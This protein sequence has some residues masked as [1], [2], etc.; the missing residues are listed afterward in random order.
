MQKVFGIAG[1][2][3]SGKTTLIVDLLEIFV[4]KG[5]RVATLKHAHHEFDI[6]H[7]GKDSYKHRKAGASEIMVVSANRWA[8]IREFADIKE[9]SFDEAL[10]QIGKVDLVLVEGW[11]YGSHPRLELRRGTLDAP[12]IAE[13]DPRIKAIVCDAGLPDAV[14]TVLLRDDIDSIAEFI[15]HE[16]DIN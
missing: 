4:R 14:V 9:P 15:L 8:H 10:A 3:N 6:D 16:L 5:L 2:K 1:F 11:K 12:P 13:Q 7:P